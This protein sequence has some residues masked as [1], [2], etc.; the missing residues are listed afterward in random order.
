MELI[1]STPPIATGYDGESDRVLAEFVS[2]KPD[3]FKV[4]GKVGQRW[5][6]DRKRLADGRPETLISDAEE[7][8]QRL[9]IDRFDLLM[10]HSVDP[11]TPID[12]SAS[13]LA[14]LHS[15]GLCDRIG[16]C[17]VTIE[18]YQ[19]FCAGLSAS[20]LSCQ[21]VQCPLN[22][23][24][25]GKLTDLIPA[26]HHD[27]CD[28]LAFWVLMKGLL[29]GK[30]GRDHVFA[31]G[32]SRPN[33]EIFQGEQREKVHQVLDHL[34]VIAKQTG[35]TIAQLSIGWALSQEGVSGALIGARRPD[36][37]AETARSQPLPRDVLE[38]IET[39]LS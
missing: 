7:S 2:G 11:N 22:M 23:M 4:I 35:Q 17:N 29:A 5:T 30:I 8:L 19:A 24:Q 14:Q 37:I 1:R 36:Q 16:V 21:A 25:R 38:A 6:P 39:R 12:Q 27:E 10:L 33:Y 13:A 18:E 15:R 3:R 9:K 26:C 34:N 31:E 32:D 20:G 28:V